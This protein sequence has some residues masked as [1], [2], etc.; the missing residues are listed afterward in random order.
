MQLPPTMALATVLI[1]ATASS[2]RA[3]GVPG[4]TAALEAVALCHA[5]ARTPDRTLRAALLERGLALAEAAAARDDT[6]AA[7]H[8]AIF[9]T[10]GRQLQERALG[11]RTLGAIRRARRA[12]DRA[13]ALA[14]ASAELLTA[15]G[16]MLLR[17]PRLLGG[18]PGEGELLLRRA[19][20][21]SPGFAAAVQTLAERPA[22]TAPTSR[23]G[24]R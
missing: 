21:L 24:C 7:A 18:D 15:K 13:L 10:L 11:W 9:C 23:R 22:K 12:I 6:D 20:E 5:A 14:P 8:F 16:V 3:D 17:L 19:L 4:S 1:L 2:G